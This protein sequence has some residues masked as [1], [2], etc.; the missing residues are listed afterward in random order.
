MSFL[1]F[2][3]LTALKVEA[4]RRRRNNGGDG[5]GSSGEEEGDRV[6]LDVM[7]WGAIMAPLYLGIGLLCCF[8]CIARRRF[9]AGTAH[10]VVGT[11]FGFPLV[12]VLV[13]ANIKLD[14][15]RGGGLSLALVF[16]PLWILAGLF[17]CV[18]LGMCLHAARQRCTR[19]AAE[20]QRERAA[21]LHWQEH[22]ALLGGSY[23]HAGLRRDAAG[24][25]LAVFFLLVC[26]AGPWILFEI[27][28]S[29]HVDRGT[30]SSGVSARGA[31]APLMIWF[32][33]LSLFLI[34]YAWNRRPLR[35][36]PVL[37]PV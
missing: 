3:A 36:A 14:A 7:P 5:S 25:A 19:N 13:L 26:I 12:L 28:L 34:T 18:P 1:L 31:F 9:E 29:V 2:L 10:L 35:P 4:A 30:K 17:F 32:A 22:G 11:L 24:D 15:P 6:F 16:V 21:R 20:R 8:P 23:G 37:L 33:F 27:L